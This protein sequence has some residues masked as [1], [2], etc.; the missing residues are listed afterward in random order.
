MLAKLGKFD[1]YNNALLMG[2]IALVIICIFTAIFT[3]IYLIAGLPVLLLIAYVSFVDFK[4]VF[5]LLLACVPFSIEYY[6]PGGFG[7]D[8]PSEPLMIGLTLIYII[9]LANNWGKMSGEFIKHPLILM[10]MLHLGWMIVA[11]FNSN[12]MYVSIKF[13]LAKVW[14][15]VTFLFMAGTII[16]NEKTVRQYFWIV[17]IS[18]Q[19]VIFFT[20]IKHATLNFSFEEVNESMYPFFRNH[21]GY[22]ALL[23]LFFP[24]LWF[25]RKWYKTWSWYWW[26]LVFAA[27]IFL[28]AIQLS[29]TR[30][31]YAAIVMTAGAYFIFKFRLVKIVLAFGLI[32]VVL[33]FTALVNQNRYLNFAPDYENTITHFEFKDLMTATYQFEDISTMERVYR[34]V[35]AVRMSKDELLTGYGPGNFYNFYKNYTVLSFETYVSDNPEKSGAH[36]Y[37]LM[38]LVDQGIPGVLIFILLTCG[39]LIYGE[40]IYHRSKHKGRK[41]IVMAILLAFTVIFAFS[42]INDLLETDKIGAF[43]FVNLAILVNIDLANKRALNGTDTW[44]DYD[45]TP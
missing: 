20:I 3:N 1:K 42:L 37:Y 21:V 36:N 34:W 29:Y 30:A 43:F 27:L 13:V 41:R 23:A 32:I 17:Y 12:L 22:S 18:F 4:Q 9:Y 45:L 31:A 16:K 19:L 10:V 11:M 39:I 2:F 38:L 24:F 14:Y 5:F 40:N 15:L 33:G 6:L 26:V 44:N 8:L 28:V 25:A 35:A 7:T